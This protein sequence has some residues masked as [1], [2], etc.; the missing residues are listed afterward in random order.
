MSKIR[1]RIATILYHTGP[2]YGY[3]IYKDYVKVFGK[4][5]M[6]TFYYNLTKGLS[7]GEFVIVEVKEEQGAF[8]WGSKVERVY[9]DIGPNYELVD[10]TKLQ[11]DKISTLNK[12][13]IQ[14]DFNKVK[15]ETKKKFEEELKKA[16]EKG[17]MKEVKRVEG[18][19]DKIKTWH[20]HTYISGGTHFPK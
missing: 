20:P 16:V 3:Q 7:T 18:I 2:N 15:E 1:Q 4:I 17:D 13:N 14:Y 12:T 11:M 9:Y 5:L 6:R 10:L 19:L 8:T